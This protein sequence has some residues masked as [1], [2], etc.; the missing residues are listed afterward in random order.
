MSKST[1]TK[2]PTGRP[3]IKRPAFLFAAAALVALVVGCASAPLVPVEEGTGAVAIDLALWRN[4]GKLSDILIG[5]AASATV[6]YFARLDDDGGDPFTGTDIKAT[7]YTSG[8]GHAYLLNAPPG[9][10]VAVAAA[11]EFT[12]DK[13]VFHYTFYFPPEMIEQTSVDVMEGALSFMGEYQIK[14]HILPRVVEPAQIH[15]R[16]LLKNFMGTSAGAVPLTGSS[17][18]EHTWHATTSH[19][20]MART[21]ADAE[22]SFLKKAAKYMEGTPWAAMV[23]GRIKSIDHGKAYGEADGKAHTDETLK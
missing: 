11:A 12:D 20:R 19:V 23:K 6:V 1:G 17:G 5:D 15:Y 9:R 16:A 10:Y 2:V 22:R 18:T 13:K 14:E 7:N 21:S 8:T 4:E 3:G